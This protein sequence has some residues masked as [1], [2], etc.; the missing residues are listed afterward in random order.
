MSVPS[1]IFEIRLTPE[2]PCQTISV[3]LEKFMT[4]LADNTDAIYKDGTFPSDEVRTLE[5]QLHA[6]KRDLRLREL[7]F[8]FLFPRSVESPSLFCR[9]RRWWVLGLVRG[10]RWVCGRKHLCWTFRTSLSPRLNTLLYNWGFNFVYEMHHPRTINF[11]DS[12]QA[13]VASLEHH[14]HSFKGYTPKDEQ[15]WNN[16]GRWCV[17]QPWQTSIKDVLIEGFVEGD[18]DLRNAL[19]ANYEASRRRSTLFTATVG[20]CCYLWTQQRKSPNQTSI[21]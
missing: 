12:F 16:Y 13:L 7:A 18:Q 3:Q 1:L 14:T 17:P 19:I 2:E 21:F 8:I 10:L 5:Q 11:S 15:A 9:V 4:N 6:I 20:G